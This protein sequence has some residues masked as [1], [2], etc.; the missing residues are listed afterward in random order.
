[1]ALLPR[2]ALAGARPDRGRGALRHRDRPPDRDAAHPASAVGSELQRCGLQRGSRNTPCLDVNKRL[3]VFNAASRAR[4]YESHLSNAQLRLKFYVTLLKIAVYKFLAAYY[5]GFIMKNEYDVNQ[6][7]DSNG[8]VAEGGKWPCVEP[9]FCQGWREQ[10]EDRNLNV[11]LRA[12]RELASSG[13]SRVYPLLIDVLLQDEPRLHR[14]VEKMLSGLGK[15][16]WLALVLADE[17]KWNALVV[18]N[19]PILMDAIFSRYVQRHVMAALSHGDISLPE[20]LVMRFF[21]VPQKDPVAYEAALGLLKKHKGS[22]E[23][24]TFKLL[25]MELIRAKL[26]DK[27]DAC[28][29]KLADFSAAVRLENVLRLGQLKDVAAVIPLIQ[30]LGDEHDF[31]RM[32]AVEALSRL[33]DLRAADPL[34]EVLRHDPVPMVRKQAVLA[35]ASLRDPTLVPKLIHALRDLDFSVFKNV[36]FVL[37]VLHDKAGDEALA[38]I[39][40][41]HSAAEFRREIVVALVGVSGRHVTHA[42]KMIAAEDPCIENREKAKNVLKERKKGN[43][44]RKE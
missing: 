15:N 11:R 12:V 24:E 10:L 6:V 34:T 1:M 9:A 23:F 40:L 5:S 38:E 20:K 44:V 4:G 43:R 33:E 31:V 17:T 30:R 3:V 21:A 36:V 32:A 26:R 18:S 28:L 37:S 42:L 41:T 39:M 27:V 13:D 8:D 2:E 16:D 35:L 7:V 22:I 25:V 29:A 14:E 19:A